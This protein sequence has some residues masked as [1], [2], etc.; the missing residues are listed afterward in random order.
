MQADDSFLPAER[1]PEPDPDNV[2]LGYWTAARDEKLV[3]QRC[4]AC[5]QSQYPPDVVCHHCGSR[6]LSYAESKGRGSIYSFAIYERTL[7]AG[8]EVPYVLALIQLDDHPGVRM[9]TNVV[10]TPFERLRVGLDVECIFEARGS[11]R[12]PQFREATGAIP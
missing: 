2:S 4:E 1:K 5:N 3:V 11:W 12:I 9:M 8:F 10:D 6:D 7:M